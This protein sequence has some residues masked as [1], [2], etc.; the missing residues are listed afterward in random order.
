VRSQL[1]ANPGEVEN[2]SDPADLMIVRNPGFEVERIEQLTRLTLCVAPASNSSADGRLKS[3]ESRFA[4]PLKLVLQQYRPETEIT[5]NLRPTFAH[6]SIRHRKCR[7]ADAMSQLRD[8][9]VEQV[10]TQAGEALSV[11]SGDRGPKQR[12]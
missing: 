4:E 11:A 8:V 12:P 2:R 5:S 6:A 10:L 7:E 3:T 1:G 9:D